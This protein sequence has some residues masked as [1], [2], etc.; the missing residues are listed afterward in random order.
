MTIKTACNEP[1]HAD[2]NRQRQQ[3]ARPAPASHLLAKVTVAAIAISLAGCQSPPARDGDLFRKPAGHVT[4]WSSFENPTAA[5][6]RGALENKA[7]K[8]HAFDYIGPGQSR[9]LLD[10]KGSGIVTRIWLTVMDRSPKMLRSLRID[11]FWDDAKTPAVSAP[12]G[13][14]FG[15][16]LGRCVPFENALFA[17]P[18]GR[19]FNCYVPMPFRTAARIV[20]T[21]DSDK[22]LS[23]LFYDVDFTL[24]PPHGPDV[25]YFHAHWRREKPTTLGRDFEILP[26][27]RGRGR[28]LGSNIGVII[29]PV[30]GESWW[31]EGEVK[32]YL[33]GDDAHP[34]LVGTGTEDYIGTGWGQGTY[35]GRYQGCLIADN[36][37][38]QW[39]FYRYHIPDPVWFDADCR[40][41]MQQVGGIG[42]DYVRGLLKKGAPLIPISIDAGGGD[43]F[44]RLLDKRGK[45]DLSDPSLPGGHCNFYRRDDWS[46]TSYFYLDRPESGLPPLAPV[47]ERI[48]GVE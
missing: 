33:D 30:Y 43:K 13:D 4:R 14:F 26:K 48:A 45:L 46:A 9:T 8:G 22:R 16:G 10:V 29:D 27:V 19:S 23:H 37:K 47:A 7:A 20:V 3:A 11:M 24:T 41:T 25:L 21:N 34:T 2:Q 32:I 35:A 38:R 15:L 28:F 6:G 40:V 31:G 1:E 36:T 5:K 18:E 39:A 42:L 44:T 12:L 17:D